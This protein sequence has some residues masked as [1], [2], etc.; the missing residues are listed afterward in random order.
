MFSLWYRCEA[1]VLVVGV[2]PGLVSCGVMSLLSLMRPL[3]WVAP[4]IPVLP[5]KHLD[6][7]ESPVPIVAGLVLDPADKGLN[8]MKIME[9]C[10]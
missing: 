1:K 9:L 8:P 10:E 6:F 3:S 7:I 4:V 2:E 5:I